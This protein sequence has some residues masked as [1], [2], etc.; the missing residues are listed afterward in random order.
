M[1]N[2]NL[3]R[4]MKIAMIGCGAMSEFH[5]DAIR[6]VGLEITDIAASPNSQ[7]VRNFA[8][9]H[10]IPNVW[11]NPVQLIE[12][13]D[14]NGLIISS[15]IDSTF[16]LL[17]HAIARDIPVLV[18]KPVT[19]QSNI[20]SQVN[21]VNPKVM[22]GY[23]RRFY[24]AFQEMKKTLE[25]TGPSMISVEI[26]EIL[27]ESSIDTF[28]KFQ[29]VRENSVHVFDLLRFLAGEIEILSLKKLQSRKK[30]EGT[31]AIL[32]SNQGHLISV[33][34]NYNASSNFKI[35]IDDGVSRYKFDPLE[36][37]AIYK[38]MDI[39]EPKKGQTTR[40]YRPKLILSK[41]SDPEEGL[42]KPG[43]FGQASAFRK[44]VL[45]EESNF[46]ASLED[47][48]KALKIAEALT[49]SE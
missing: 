22:V 36:E 42:Y 37:V 35:N 41:R 14:W 26:P 11:A 40:S 47:A 28:V 39:S 38:G 21:L 4:K 46:H 24:P 45:G 10:M 34:M 48:L 23:N 33:V 18:E 13:G 31:L 9:R 1:N 12:D 6:G 2:N 17:Q 29:N 43:F 15:S 27:K 44:M 3:E 20:L 30:N 32:Q 5:L 49:S 25:A 7:K 8:D 16:G 19:S